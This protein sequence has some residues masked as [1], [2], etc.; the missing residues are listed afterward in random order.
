[1]FVIPCKYEKESPIKKCIDSI[2]EYHPNEKI[3][4]VD[5][6]SEDDSYLSTFNDYANV[7]V[8]DHKNNQY[9]VGALFKVMQDC[10]DEDN[11]VLIHDTLKFNSSISSYLNDDSESYGFWCFYDRFTHFLHMPE[12]VEYIIDMLRDT[13]YDIPKIDELFWGVPFHHCII[14][15]SMKTKIINSGILEKFYLNKK[16][17]DNGW[18]RLLG[19]IFSQEGFCPKDYNI[20]G[21]NTLDTRRINKFFEKHYL[22]RS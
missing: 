1:M 16:V 21:D 11:Y 2:I 8:F 7:E 4:I 17:H 10:P 19:I 15:N 18:E 12:M 14:K 20:A 5:S 22:G 3:M 6:F 9:P 13:K